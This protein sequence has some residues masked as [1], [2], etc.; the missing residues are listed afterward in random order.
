M[1]LVVAGGTVAII[2]VFTYL[3][4]A[5]LGDAIQNSLQGRVLLAQTTARSIDYVLSGVENVLT[6]AVAEENWSEPGNND[7]ALA[8]VAQRL[9]FYSTQ[10]FLLD[11]TGRVVAARP[12]LKSAVSFDGF[13]SVAA[14][15]NGQ[16]FAVSRFVHPLGPI[17]SST[18]AA[19][20]VYDHSGNLIGALV[21]SINL[22]SPNIRT[23]T[24]PIGLGDTGT[25]DLVD[26]GGVILAS[27][28]PQ[29]VG[30][31]SDQGQSLEGMILSHQQGVVSCRDCDTAA[32]TPQPGTEVLAFA[33]LE[34]AQWGV[35][36]RQSEAEV[37]SATRLLQWRIFGFAVI[38]LAGGL[39]L[40]YFTSRSVVHPVQALIGATQL[41]AAG[42]LDTAIDIHGQDEVNTLARSFDSMRTRL[43][44]TISEIK[45]WNRE[46]DRRVQ[47]QTA[48]C[49]DAL[50][51][52]TLLLAELQHKEKLRCEL[53]HQV[54]SAQ[55]EERKRL[56]RE[57]HDETCQTITAL[58]YKL[59]DAGESAVS[60]EIHALLEQ[61]HGMAD[62]TQEE[63]HRII[64]DLRPTMLDH[65]GLIPALRWYAE[66]RFSDLRIR[67]NIR[68]VGCIRRLSPAAEIT[69]F[70]VVQE[71]VNNIARHSKA[72]AADFDFEFFDD[73]VEVRIADNGVGFDA[74]SVADGSDGHRGL[75]L[76]GMAERMSAID[77]E[78]Q[79]RSTPGQ[80]TTI[81]LVVKQDTENGEDT[82]SGS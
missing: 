64:M 74:A 19:T 37:F 57:L 13:A 77:G 7:Q 59:D 14:A 48:V 46:L 61:M 54:I 75:G 65:L 12:P 36:I 58:A 30:L 20:P 60:P 27:S 81:E 69:L 71:A 29:R 33:P 80:G 16:S 1:A 40:V 28:R 41:I 31:K 70:R 24:D 79:L 82:N 56:S 11:R 45:A 10:L 23:F 52:N 32:G 50:D 9:A 68:V 3:G 55:E 51:K 5:A 39:T 44:D 34:R 73:R 43:K 47:E 21:I 67:S 78:F 49:R 72:R 76:M 17:G 62:A 2:S 18:V 4:T 15:L 66:K 53:L 42:D 26:L 6:A 25:M 63:L 8:H 38:V 22:T 35:A